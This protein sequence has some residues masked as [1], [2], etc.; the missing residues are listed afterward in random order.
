MCT[1]RIRTK[2]FHGAKVPSFAIF[3]FISIWC[4]VLFVMFLLATCISS[5]RTALIT[6]SHRTC[7]CCLYG[8]AEA[9]WRKPTTNA[10]GC[11]SVCE[12][13]F[14]KHCHFDVK[15]MFH[16][17][18][19]NDLSVSSI[20]KIF[21]VKSDISIMIT[22]F[23]KPKMRAEIQRQVY[24]NDSI[25]ISNQLKPSNTHTFSSIIDFFK[26]ISVDSVNLGRFL[27]QKPLLFTTWVIYHTCSHFVSPSADASELIL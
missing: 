13:V 17:E 10:F 2:C 20:L 26:W 7:E 22:T 25:N 21:R 24:L 8:D 1:I 14:W 12:R 16:Y 3:S 18:M 23:F 4:V 6:R 5:R 9:W 11:V 15:W 19:P 27:A